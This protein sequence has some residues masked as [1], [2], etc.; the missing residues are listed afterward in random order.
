M[1][2]GTGHRQFLGATASRPEQSIKGWIMSFPMMKRTRGWVV[3]AATAGLLGGLGLMAPA[4]AGAAESNQTVSVT[5]RMAASGHVTWSGWRQQNGNWSSRCG[6]S[7]SYFKVSYTGEYKIYA[8]LRA[9]TIDDYDD[10]DDFKNGTLKF[11]SGALT[12]SRTRFEDYVRSGQSVLGVG[13]YDRFSGER[14]W[15]SLWNYSIPCGYDLE[16]NFRDDD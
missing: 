5:A 3:A 14:L 10:Y 11:S 2:A 16:V 15:W 1:T 4:P 12:P 6:K 9:G 13:V 7:E 8:H